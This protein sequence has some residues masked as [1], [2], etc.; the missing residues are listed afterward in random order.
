MLLQ[1]QHMFRHITTRQNATMHFWM[2]GFHPTIKRN[3]A[4]RLGIMAVMLHLPCRF[5]VGPTR[6]A[7]LVPCPLRCGGGP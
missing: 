6:G 7:V 3:M 4:K 2:Q 1:R 5:C